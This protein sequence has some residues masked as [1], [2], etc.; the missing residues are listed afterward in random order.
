M[1]AIRSVPGLCLSQTM[2]IW[3]VILTQLF[4]FTYSLKLKKITPHHNSTRVLPSTVRRSRGMQSLA[5]H[6]Q[7]VTGYGFDSSKTIILSDDCCSHIQSQ[8]WT[9]ASSTYIMS[10][11]HVSSFQVSSVSPELKVQ[12]P[13]E[14]RAN[15]KIT[16]SMYRDSHY[17]AETVVR[18]AQLYNG[19]PYT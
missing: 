11:R 16:V 3:L 8:S 14:L 13:A 9:W 10:A 6:G 2:L 4:Y 12:S 18:P 19:N 5:E 7:T 17:K 1:A 15:S